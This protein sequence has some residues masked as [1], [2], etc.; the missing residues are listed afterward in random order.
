MENVSSKFTEFKINISFFLRYFLCTKLKQCN[1]TITDMGTGFAA[2]K[3]L[4]NMCTR[5]TMGL[6]CTLCLVQY[7]TFTSC[8]DHV[9]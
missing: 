8:K 6:N 1:H 9:W 2:D 4:Y 3:I 7:L 5:H